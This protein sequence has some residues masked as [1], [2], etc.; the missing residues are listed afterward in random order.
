MK[1]SMTIATLAAF[2]APFFSLAAGADEEKVPLDKV[3]AAV[4]KA[5]KDKFPKA[6]IKE[7][8]KEVED[9]VTKFEVA[10]MDA[11]RNVDMTMKEDGTVL[12]V[13]K[14]IAEADLPKAVADAFKT[15]YPKAK[16]NMAEEV[17]KEG[18]SLYE[19]HFK[20]GEKTKEAV[21][22]PAGKLVEE[23]DGDEG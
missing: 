14:E 5:V 9:G 22:D 8:S 21:Y 3:P 12:E 1:G 23:E 6:E 10:L 15:K 18:K 11:G 4:T 17:S 20:D 16:I 2:A 19:L 7:A 13:E